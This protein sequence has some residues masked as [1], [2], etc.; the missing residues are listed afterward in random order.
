MGDA[1]N[2]IEGIDSMF[3]AAWKT[4]KPAL[5]PVVVVQPNGRDYNIRGTGFFINRD[6]TFVTCAHVLDP[7]ITLPYRYTGRPGEAVQYPQLPISI[8][9]RDVGADVAIGRVDG[10]DVP[11]ILAL[12][13]DEVLAG[14]SVA[15][16]G[17]PPFEDRAGAMVAYTATFQPT[18][19]LE[20]GMTGGA[21]QERVVVM[22][23]NPFF[24]MS[25]GPIVDVHGAVVGLQSRVVH[26]RFNRGSGGREFR[27]E[28]GLGVEVDVIRGALSAVAADQQ[29][30]RTGVA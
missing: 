25:G 13:T 19:V 20:H 18:F 7:A 21:N 8:L 17:Y 1:E 10:L 22:R 29:A 3:A 9:Y 2:L 24:G 23:D 27:V 28:N 4:T 12:A 15:I 30:T 14:S 5:F 26:P 11:G 6:G 16:C